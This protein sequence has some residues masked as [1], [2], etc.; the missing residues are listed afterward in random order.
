MG[1]QTLG[2]ERQRPYHKLRSII[3][4]KQK[5]LDELNRARDKAARDFDAVAKRIAEEQARKIIEERKE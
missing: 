1:I 3:D 4:D 5:M 2:V